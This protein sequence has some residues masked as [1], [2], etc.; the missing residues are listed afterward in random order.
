MKAAVSHGDGHHV[1][2]LHLRHKRTEK[3]VGCIHHFE[4]VDAGFDSQIVEDSDGDFG[5]NIAGAAAQTVECG[6][7]HGRAAAEGLDT[8]GHRELQ[9]AVPVEAEGALGKRRAPRSDSGRI[10]SGN[11]LPAEST[12]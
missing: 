7:D 9:I 8:I 4:K 6:V 1:V 11:M 2:E 3:L 12:Q 5:G 10:S